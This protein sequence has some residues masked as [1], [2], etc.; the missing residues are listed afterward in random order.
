MYMVKGV[1]T[2]QNPGCARTN[3]LWL[4]LNLSDRCKADDHIRG[5]WKHIAGGA[6][7]GGEPRPCQAIC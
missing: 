7:A 2:P 4:D 1:T 5:C 6:G 3:Q